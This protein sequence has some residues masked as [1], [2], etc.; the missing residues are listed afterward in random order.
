MRPGSLQLPGRISFLTRASAKGR[1]TRNGDPL[2]EGE[3]YFLHTFFL[4]RRKR[5]LWY[6]CSTYLTK[7]VSSFQR[8]S[9]GVTCSTA[10]V[11]LLLTTTAITFA[12]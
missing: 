5:Q 6:N 4:I 12:L 9:S 3:M 8:H 1:K 11:L 7:D 2:F 10:I